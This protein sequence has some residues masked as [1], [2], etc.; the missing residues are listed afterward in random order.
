M[1]DIHADES[2][3]R[4]PDRL[5]VGDGEGSAR[6]AD[7][8]RAVVADAAPRSQNGSSDDHRASEVRGAR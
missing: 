8:P 6:S 1:P 2:E 3:A 7:A 5:V 4:K